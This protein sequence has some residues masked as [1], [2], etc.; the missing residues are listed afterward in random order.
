[1]VIHR[2]I[3]PNNVLVTLNGTPKLLDFGIAKILGP[4]VVGGKVENTTTLFRPLTPG[5]ASPEQI[6]GE[7]VTT[8]SDV[9]SLGVVLYEL[10]SGCHPYQVHELSSSQITDAVCQIIPQKPS[11]AA[12]RATSIVPGVAAKSLVGDLDNIVLMALRKEPQRRYS[13]VE[14]LGADIRRHL[15]NLPV[16]ASEDTFGYR[17]AKFVA[18]HRTMVV[19]AATVA[20]TLFV[21]L[22]VTISEARIAKRRFDDLHTLAK[23]LMFEIHDSIQDLPG[24]TSARQLI[25]TRALQYLDG[26]ALQANGDVAL[27]RELAAGYKRIGNVQGYQFSANLGDTAGALK[28]YNKALAIQEALPEKST[29]NVSDGIALGETLRLIAETSIVINQS[30]AASSYIHRA[31]EIT[32][33]LQLKHPNDSNLLEEL[34]REYEAEAD[35]FAGSF[36]LSNLGNIAEGTAA[37]EKQLVVAERWAQLEPNN[38]SALR[39]LAVSMTNMGDHDLLIGNRNAAQKCYSQA[40]RTFEDLAREAT[41]NKSLEA[42]SAIYTRIEFVQ[43]SNS[44]P[45]SAILTDK[46]A[47]D[48]SARRVS[49][50][51]ND[52][53]AKLSLAEDYANLADALSQTR[54]KD[55]A[56]PAIGEAKAL[57]R[58]LVR[59]NPRNSEFLGVELAENV[60]AGD[61]CRRRSEYGQALEYYRTALVIALQVQTADPENAD[62]VQRSAAVYEKLGMALALL[63]D[64]A[65]ATAMYHKALEFSEPSEKGPSSEQP[66]Y[67]SADSYAGLGQ[68]ELMIA[69]RASL[70]PSAR[71]DHLQKS[72]SLLERSL[73]VWKKVKEPG[74]LS[75]DGFESISPNLVKEWLVRC[76]FELTDAQAKHS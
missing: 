69:R 42:L 17:L 48:V 67:T 31:L 70:S 59:L 61:V 72:Q 2:D 23:S 30:K 56:V 3:K 24:S 43:L 52:V 35:I 1:L 21:A 53:R 18:R 44:D 47:L 58:D 76:R 10:L 73:E 36:N 16:I 75:P 26:L 37:R 38:P 8:T 46:K 12:Q 19:A 50:D 40:Q 64:Y 71:V 49:A 55:Q 68:I 32:E 5:Y 63:H 4:T 27:Q 57:M 74:L 39:N 29:A 45:E 25:V 9:Y 11:K 15:K 62:A 66:F 65:G 60:T 41:S 54:K 6:R 22:L 51:P 7:S 20:I 34:G 33:S 13:S 28:S 14:Q